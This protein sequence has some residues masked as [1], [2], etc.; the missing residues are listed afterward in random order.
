MGRQLGKGAAQRK[1]ENAA[2][3]GQNVPDEVRAKVEGKGKSR[4]TTSRDEIK[5]GGKGGRK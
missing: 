5:R 4:Y 1:A 2:G 3:M